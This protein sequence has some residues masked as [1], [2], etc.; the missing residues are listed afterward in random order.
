MDSM[1]EI[2]LSSTDQ[3]LAAGEAVEPAF[4]MDETRFR[5]FYERTARPL[6]SY[7]ARIAGDASV[8]DDLLQE[9]YYHFLRADVRGR[10]GLSEMSEAHQKNY[11]FRIATNLARDHWRRA[12][13]QSVPLVEMAS[14]ERTADD[15]EQRSDLVGALESLKPRERQLLWLAYVEGSSHKEIGEI[16]GLRSASVRLLL[17]RARR[18]LAGLLRRRGVRPEG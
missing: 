8:A 11:L 10:K 18:K 4:P 13:P 1:R 2:T 14:R 15:V 17:F 5:A 9:S 6:R 7:L 3:L 12:K 16:V